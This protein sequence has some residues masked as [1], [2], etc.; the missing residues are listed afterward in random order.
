MTN[1]GVNSDINTINEK[2]PDY[3]DVG[4]SSLSSMSPPP[5]PGISSTTS[6][7]GKKT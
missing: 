5:Y 1:I 4:I 6:E 7:E 2:P 3:K